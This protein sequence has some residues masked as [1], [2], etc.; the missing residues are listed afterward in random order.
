MTSLYDGD[1]PSYI[2]TA[3]KDRAN[4][5]LTNPDMLHLGILPH[6]TKWIN[7]FEHLRYVVLDEVH[8]YRGVFG[9]HVAN[10]FRRLNRILDFYGTKVTYVLTSATISNPRE[11][12][13]KLIGKPFHLVEED[14]APKGDRNFIFYNPPIVNEELGIRQGII[15]TS[16]DFSKLI[17]DYKVQSLLFT[18]SRRAVELIIHELRKL[19]PEKSTTVRGYRS[20]YL[21]SERREIEQGLKNGT[22]NLAVATNALELGV[23]IG[24]VDLVL[25]AGYPGTITS[26]RQRAG[27]AGR[28]KS[29]SAAIF[30]ASSAPLDQF[31][32]RHPEFVME[33]NPESA[34]IDPN[35]PLILITQIQCAAFELPFAQGDAFGSV[36]WE[37]LSQY[38]EVLKLQGTIVN[39]GEKYFWLSDAYPAGGFSLRSTASKTI[40]L[41]I[42]TAEETRKIGD[43]DFNSSL[44]MTHPGAIY[45]HEGDT[46]LVESLDVESGV[47]ILTPTTVSFFTEPVKTQEIQVLRDITSTPGESRDI[48]FSEIEVTTRIE[49]YKRIDWETRTVLSV[50]PL[51]LPETKLHTFGYWIAIHPATVEMMRQEKMWTSD[52]NDYG[53][54]WE[55]QRNLAR[56]RDQYRCRICGLPETDKPYHVHHKVPFRMF[57]NIELANSLENLVTLCSSCHR[58]AELN[59]RIRSAI[60]GLKYSLYSLAPL[61]VMCDENDLGAY[62]DPAAD[63]ADG[64]PVILLYD[65]IPAGMGLVESLYKKH[66]ELL[67]NAYDLITHCS[68]EDGCPS[69]VGPTMESGLGGKKETKYLLELL[70][71]R[72]KLDGPSL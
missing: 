11:H 50:E 56:Q 48:H 65:A 36:D 1:T 34:L 27:R 30:I 12:A 47:A 4:I 70:L 7:Y 37:E 5:L 68:C 13:E 20:G 38:L 15:S 42:Q 28:K 14:G 69:C 31:L 46:Y 54:G 71:E 59:V 61:F 51:D 39:R 25:M 57:T 49:S 41:E 55:A 64:Q 66:N 52:A 45:L 43:V 6:H 35:N 53:P 33:K 16:V 29:E 58:L 26:T 18:R 40:S 23:D 44:W 60:S 72:R 63:F 17:L 10:I 62:A 9:S 2:R 19:F 32:V 67:E 21:K 8:I 22:V 24:G 3:V